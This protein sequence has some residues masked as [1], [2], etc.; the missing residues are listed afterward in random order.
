MGERAFDWT[1][2]IVFLLIAVG[3]VARVI[4]QVPFVVY[5]ISI[6]MWASGVAAIVMGVLA[7]EGL[8]LARKSPPHV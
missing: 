1:A 3:H 4:F 6:P 7:Y 5:D 8:H 2:G